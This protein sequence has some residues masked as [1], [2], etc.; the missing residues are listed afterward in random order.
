M[1]LVICWPWTFIFADTIAK[2]DEVLELM[3]TLILAIVDGM[4]NIPKDTLSEIKIY[5]QNAYDK[6]D[7][8]MT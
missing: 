2:F 3:N 8:F 4:V 6:I 7:L 1:T 5:L